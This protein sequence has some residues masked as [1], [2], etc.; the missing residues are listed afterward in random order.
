MFCTIRDM[1]Y[2]ATTATATDVQQL[3]NARVSAF[4]E[5]VVQYALRDHCRHC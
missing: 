3:L 2:A 4:I 5:S 1:V